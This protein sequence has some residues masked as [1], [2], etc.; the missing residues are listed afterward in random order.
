MRLVICSAGE[1]SCVEWPAKILVGDIGPPWR[2]GL[3]YCGAGNGDHVGAEG[4]EMAKLLIIVRSGAVGEVGM[5]I[6]QLGGG[7]GAAK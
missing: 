3:L 7:I 4:R 5:G 2:K 1:C 6:G